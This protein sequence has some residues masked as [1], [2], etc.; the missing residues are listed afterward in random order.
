MSL[1]VALCNDGVRR[2]DGRPSHSGVEGGEAVI[3]PPLQGTSAYL[4]VMA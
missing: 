3:Q 2:F 4:H 1:W